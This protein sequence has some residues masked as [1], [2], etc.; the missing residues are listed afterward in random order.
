MEWE[1]TE[2]ASVVNVATPLPLSPPV[3]NIVAPSRNVTA[4]VGVPP[5]VLATVAVKVTDCPPMEGLS[6]DTTDVVVGLAL[7]TC[8]M[9]LDVLDEKFE[10]PPYWG[11]IGWVPAVRVD[12]LNVAAALEFNGAVPI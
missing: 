2:S 3:P 1:P 8:A 6:D 9:I 4:P 10:S 7:T 5:A 12:M 11:V